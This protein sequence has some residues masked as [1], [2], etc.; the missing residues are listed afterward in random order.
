MDRYK[1]RLFPNPAFIVFALASPMMIPSCANATIF[2]IPGEHPV[3]RSRR[4]WRQE[5]AEQGNGAEDLL[6]SKKSSNTN[7]SVST[8]VNGG[9]NGPDQGSQVLVSSFL[10]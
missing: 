5:C 10:A 6:P 4:R 2:S 8:T 9:S 1:I 7:T 3:L